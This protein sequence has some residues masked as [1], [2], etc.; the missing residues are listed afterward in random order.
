MYSIPATE[1]EMAAARMFMDGRPPLSFF[2]DGR[3]FPEG[4]V[5][6]E[7]GYS[8]SDG[9]LLCELAPHAYEQSSAVE[10][11]PRFRCISG[12]RSGK[13][14]DIK[15]LDYVFPCAKKATLYYVNGPDGKIDDFNLHTREITSQPFVMESNGSKSFLPFFNLDTGNGGVILGL[16]F[17]ADWVAVFEKVQNGIHVTV[18]MPETDFF[19]YNGEAVRHIRVLTIFWQGERS[20]SFNLLRNHLVRHCIPCDENGEP[21]PP[22]CCISWGGMKTANHLK[23]IRFLQENHMRYDCY[24]IDAGWYGPDHETDEF[25]NIDVEDWAYHQ[26]DWTVNRC[27]HPEGLQPVSA[28]AHAAGMK[29][30]LWFSTYCCNEGIGWQKEHPEWG[31]GTPMPDGIGRNPQPTVI[32]TINMNHPEARRYIIETVCTALKENGVDYYREDTL[33][34]YGGAD[35][36]GRTGV[37]EMKA[38]QQMY[39]F[40]DELLARFP[41]MLIDNCGG[42]GTHIDLETLQRSYVLWRSDYNC[43]PDADPIGAQTGNYGL[44]HFVPLVGCTPPSNPGSTYAFHS[45]LYG[46]MNFG[47]FHPVGP[48]NEAEKHTW[49]APD[50]PLEWHKRMLDEYQM[51]KPYLSGCFY[52]LTPCTTKS[53]DVLAY[54]FDRPDRNSGVLFAFFRQEC[55]ETQIKISPVLAPGVYRFTNP[56][57]GDS[58]Q[59]RADDP[60]WL[61]LKAE[62]KP[63]SILLHY[64]KETD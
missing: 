4:F 33:P 49:F 35:E 28:A 38:V 23:Y 48:E 37:G 41:G 36:D 58:F 55:G 50:Y 63:S 60:F 20:R 5:K 30:L 3:P 22:M 31:E 46:G 57:T 42:G 15:A 10:W 61:L 29:L 25:Q 2:Y 14:Q 53:Q 8:S 32:H 26:G 19:L 13:V 47:L 54:Q 39:D 17:T 1:T 52:P 16:G 45:G 44:G 40:W 18:S 7:R 43:R 64:Q 9:R 56:D 62:R 51:V 24:W 11:T 6:E 34:V 21:F 27:V 59:K 12:E